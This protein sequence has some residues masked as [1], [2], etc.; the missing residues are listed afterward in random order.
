MGA[1]IRA[2]APLA[3]R[4]VDEHPFHLTVGTYLSAAGL[5]AA[6]LLITVVLGSRHGVVPTRSGAL[7]WADRTG[8]TPDR[9]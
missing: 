8:T 9:A 4:T 6:A 1:L 7:L 5:A 2:D 3:G